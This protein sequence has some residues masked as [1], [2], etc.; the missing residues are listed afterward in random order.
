MLC[1]PGGDPGR[2][3]NHQWHRAPTMYG[4]LAAWFTISSMAPSEKST[5]FKSTIGCIRSAAPTPAATMAASEIGASSTAGGRK[6][7][8]SP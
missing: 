1:R 5:K 8:R 3:P 7:V 6:P 2:G 4:I